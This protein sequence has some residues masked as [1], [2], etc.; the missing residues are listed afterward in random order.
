MKEDP[1]VKRQVD[2]IDKNNDRLFA[3]EKPQP[4]NFELEF[5]QSLT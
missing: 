4:P 3:G 5:P 1:E 2:L